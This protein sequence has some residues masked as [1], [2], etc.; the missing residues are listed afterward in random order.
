MFSRIKSF[1]IGLQHAGVMCAL[2]CLGALAGCEVVSVKPVGN[3]PMVIEPEDWEGLWVSDTGEVWAVV[4]VVNAAEGELEIA[5]IDFDEDS[6]RMDT[7]VVYLRTL[8][9]DVVAR[10]MFV[11]MYDEESD[12]YGWGLLSRDDDHVEIRLPAASRFR[13]L[14]E[15]GA[16]SGK[17][18]DNLLKTVI[19]EELTAEHLAIISAADEVLWQSG[20]PEIIRRY[21]SY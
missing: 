5:G 19:L 1:K 14:V 10:T 6:F 9:A 2:L 13:E 8:V 16:L 3:V 11:S 20:E 4:R 18:E 12:I 17:V 15:E 21:V 7:N